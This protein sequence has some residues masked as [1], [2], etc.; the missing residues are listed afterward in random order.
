MTDPNLTTPAP[1]K[2]LAALFEA[3]LTA[4]PVPKGD[5]FD[6]GGK[7]GYKY[8]SSA[9]VVRYARAHLHEHGLA[10]ILNLTTTRAS[11]I[12][13]HRGIVGLSGVLFHR[14]SGETWPIAFELPY[15]GS[16]GRPDD[17]ASQ[18]S[19]TTGEARAYRLLLGL[20][21][22]D[23]EEEV[24]S[25]LPPEL[26]RETATAPTPKAPPS[27]T[28]KPPTAAAKPPP[29]KPAPAPEPS[30]TAPDD[31][32]REERKAIQEVAAQEEAEAATAAQIEEF[33]KLAGR[34][35]LT[36]DTAVTWSSRQP[37]KRPDGSFTRMKDNPEP[38]YYNYADAKDRGRL[39]ELIPL[40]Q[41]EIDDLKS[42]KIH[43]RRSGWAGRVNKWSADAVGF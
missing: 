21:T 24:A 30:A 25:Y 33:G 20:T 14:E 36:L 43:P 15:V 31:Y 3:Q 16:K 26:A 11:S 10:V 39:A 22:L 37:L 28:A 6:A 41:E 42:R 27:T 13:G 5:D 9:D 35:G 32:A 29:S 1:V 8:A 34:L 18:A 40:L 23:P 2:L 17:K 19:I 7:F 12:D 38:R 4:K